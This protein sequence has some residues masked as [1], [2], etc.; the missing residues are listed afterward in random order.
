M[1]ITMGSLMGIM[2]GSLMGIAM[3]S[4][5]GITMGSLM[6]IMMGSVMGSLTGIM[7]GMPVSPGLMKV[8]PMGVVS[9]GKAASLLERNHS[10]ADSR[11]ARAV[12][13][14]IHCASQA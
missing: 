13:A 14:C 6:G 8:R 10:R 1:G 12:A 7:M 3:G 4:F 11:M 5:M 9:Q 2:M